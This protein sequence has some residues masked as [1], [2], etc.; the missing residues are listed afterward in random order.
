MS[1][2]SRRSVL[3]QVGQARREQARQQSCPGARLVQGSG[4]MCSR[5]ES[6]PGRALTCRG[7]YNEGKAGG[8]AGLQ[9][10]C[11]KGRAQQAF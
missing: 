10:C 3:Q 4:S 5:E 9:A 8:L 11:Q 7:W 6:W 2:R 1:H